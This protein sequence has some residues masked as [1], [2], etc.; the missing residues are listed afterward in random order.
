MKIP[1]TANFRAVILGLIAGA[2]GPTLYA[3]SFDVVSVR[4]NQTPVRESHCD[5]KVDLARLSFHGCN[6]RT[7]IGWAYD[8]G[9]SRSEGGP[10]WVAK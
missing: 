8:L 1:V 10:A 5:A 4:L 6:L 2:L 9:S 3:Q 7:V